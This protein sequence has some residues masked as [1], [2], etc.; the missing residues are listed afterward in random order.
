MVKKQ[1][2]KLEIV[3]TLKSGGIGVLPTDTMYGIVGSAL[4]KKT[5]TE[6]YHLRYRAFHKP[7]IVLISSLEDLKLLGIKTTLAHKQILEQ[8]WPGPV[9]VILPCFQKKFEYLTRGTK[10]IAVRLPKDNFLIDILKQTGPLVAPSA[11]LSAQPPAKTIKEAKKYFGNQIDFYYGGGK[12]S[13]M[14]STLIEIKK[15]ASG[16]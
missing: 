8:V 12:K 15:P 2:T 6:I 13:V 9:S 1:I 14:P 5:V 4:N 3:E 16:F 7:L 10:T 11:N